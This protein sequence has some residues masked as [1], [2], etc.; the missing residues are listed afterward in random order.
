MFKSRW[1]FIPPTTP[2]YVPLH[3]WDKKQDHPTLTTTYPIWEMMTQSNLLSATLPRDKI[4]G[5]LGICDPKDR[6]AIEID[7]TGRMTD[8]MIFRD[9]I[10]HIIQSRDHIKPLQYAASGG[11]NVIDWPSWVP[12]LSQTNPNF[13]SCFAEMGYDASYQSSGRWLR[14]NHPFL[15]AFVL[16]HP[17]IF[18]CLFLIS[19]TIAHRVANILNDSRRAGATFSDDNNVLILRGIPFDTISYADP[20]PDTGIFLSSDTVYLDQERAVTLPGVE[21]S[22]KRWQSAVASFK[23]NPYRTPEGRY[24]AYWRTIIGNRRRGPSGFVTPPDSFRMGYEIWGGARSI[25]E[26]QKDRWQ[27]LLTFGTFQGMVG[28]SLN[29]RSFA[30]TSLGYLGLVPKAAKNG[31]LICVFQGGEVPFVL[32][33]IGNDQWELVGECYVHGIMEG[34]VVK[35]AKPGDVRT[36]YLR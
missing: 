1:T 5:L 12:D 21:V 35:K 11:K 30:I 26:D 6:A 34:E 22:F 14:L 8:S 28:R 7:Y 31:D 36:Y 18:S 20:A 25:P 32:R 4:Y 19:S 24:A 16:D 3:L 10:A 15:G 27:A 29:Q 13:W 2:F 17:F 23:P 33:P 9:T